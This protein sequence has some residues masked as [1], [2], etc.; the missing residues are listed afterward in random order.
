MKKAIL[1]LFIGSIILS[2]C[3]SVESEESIPQSA[4]NQ[5]LKNQV[6]YLTNETFKQQVFN[7][8][9]NKEWKYNGT[10]PA[11][12]DFYADWCAPCRQISPVIEELAKEYDGRIIV[13]KVNTE[14]E[15]FLAQN[16]GVQALP[17]VMLIPLEGQ[18]QVI[19][20][21]LPKAELVKA[22]QEVLL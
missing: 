20:G 11:I 4:T 3:K 16:L 5:T 13:F 9:L 21:A 10:M 6:I 15:R 8:D 17:T 2:S 1:Y 14:K 12:I 7:Y 19:M 22:I 18:P